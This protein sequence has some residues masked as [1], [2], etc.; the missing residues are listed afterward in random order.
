MNKKQI[1]QGDVNIESISTLPAGLKVK[2]KD[3]TR[4]KFVLA[5]GEHTGHAHVITPIEEDTNVE[6]FEDDN[7]VLYLK[8][9]KDVTVKHEE[10][11]PVTIPAGL[12]AIDI[13]REQ[14][15]LKNAME[16]VRD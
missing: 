3:V 14:N 6:L 15:H 1:Q 16:R 11:K 9:D 5:Y 10:H 13:V 7:G 12:H 4:G 2:A 8:S